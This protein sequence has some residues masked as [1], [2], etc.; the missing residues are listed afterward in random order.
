MV[1]SRDTALSR[2]VVVGVPSGRFVWIDTLSV[3]GDYEFSWSPDSHL[4]AV[5]R[6]TAIDSETEEATATELWL[7]A[8]DGKTRCKLATTPGFL[9]RQPE[10]LSR[11]ELRVSHARGASSEVGEDRVVY[12]VSEGAQP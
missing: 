2:L 7:I 8:R 3:F 1:S 12:Q 11:S 5:V 4:L 6:P 10:W 9:E